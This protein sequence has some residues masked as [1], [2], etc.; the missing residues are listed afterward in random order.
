MLIIEVL[1]DVTYKYPEFADAMNWI[2][3]N[4]SSLNDLLRECIQ[5]KYIMTRRSVC[6]DNLNVVHIATMNFLDRD[7]LKVVP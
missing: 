3:E 6:E 5:I 1:D 7:W 4:Y 2:V